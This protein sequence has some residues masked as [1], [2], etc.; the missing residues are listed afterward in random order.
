MTLVHKRAAGVLPDLQATESVLK[1][2]QNYDFTMDKV[3]VVAQ[4]VSQDNQSIR[5]LDEF[6]RQKKLEWLEHGAIAGGTL[7]G[8][9]GLLMG[10][11]L[12]AIPGVGPVA[13]AG[14]GTGFV[15]MLT[16]VFYGTVSGSLLGAAF[17]SNITPEQ[18]RLYTEQLMQGHYLVVVEG[19]AEEIARAESILKAQSI[20][21]WGIFDTL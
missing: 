11:S 8:I 10:L 17:G 13:I 4:H 20:Q 5:S 2:L 15:G 1:Q 19:T 14:S 16:G 9:S 21:N 7:G 6:A 3:S 12:L 18:I